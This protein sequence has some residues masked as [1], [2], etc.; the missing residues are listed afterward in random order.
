VI[1]LED[2]AVALGDTPVLR[3]ATLTVEAGELVGLVG[4]NGAGKTTLLRTING[5]LTPDSGAVAVAGESVVDRAARDVGRR[6][7]TVPQQTHVAFAFT[8]EQLVEMGRTPHRPRL[9]ADPDP[10]AVD[11]ALERTDTARFSDRRVDDLSGGE[12]QRVLLAR[13]LAQ[14]TPAFVLD[15][16]TANLD[17]NHQVGV[18]SLVRELVAADRG[19]LAAIH[20]LDLAA[21]FCDRLV[22]LA[23]GRVQAAGPPAA[24]LER[25][26][27]QAAFDTETAV[28]AN[29]VTGTPTV[30][31]LAE[32]G[33]GGPRV[34]VV[35]TGP[36]AART[37]AVLTEA[38]AAPS[39]G[40]VPRGDVAA[41]AA[42]A[43]DVATVR[44]DP[45]TAPDDATLARARELRAAAAACVY[46]PHPE[47]P[48]L[49]APVR[50]AVSPDLRL[51][52]DREVEGTQPRDLLGM[53]GIE[54]ATPIPSDD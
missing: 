24:V 26:V 38:G 32:R 33:G 46:V 10:G 21:R 36:R 28:T 30:T 4:P 44:S 54:G 17:I 15:E 27:L 23:G 19:A 14:E 35:G 42:E 13:A 34:H 50:E 52:E 37:L 2:V 48:D 12:R 3:E 43:L 7:A 11:R 53:V 39:L 6:V 8:V 49:P 31:A 1:E 41:E 40:P 20:D 51:G 25:D 5:V 47:G 45:L 9:G 22:V 18:L 29:P 16:P